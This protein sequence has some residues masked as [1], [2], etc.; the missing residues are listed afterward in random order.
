MLP[1]GA[2]GK[3]YIEEGSCLMKLQINHTSLRKI[4][5]EAIHVMSTLL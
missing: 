5:L 1:S 3:N 4:V 2:A